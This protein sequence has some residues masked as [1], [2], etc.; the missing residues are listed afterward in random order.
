[1]HRCDYP[2]PALQAGGHWF[3]SS[4][5]HRRNAC[6]DEA[7]WS[8]SSSEGLPDSPHGSALEAIV[9]STAQAALRWPRGTRSARRF[10]KEKMYER[11]IPL[12]LPVVQARSGDGLDGRRRIGLN[13]AEGDVGTADAPRAPPHASLA[14]QPDEGRDAA[15]GEGVAAADR[16]AQQIGGYCRVLAHSRPIAIAILRR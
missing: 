5:A 7:S 14:T 8:A 11:A 12:R 2:R 13:P 4:T 16:C 3:K 9:G 6:R 1:M 10:V 15:L